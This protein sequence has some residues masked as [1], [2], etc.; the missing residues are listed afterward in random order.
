MTATA[1]ESAAA[2]RRAIQ[3]CA[4]ITSRMLAAAEAGDWGTVAEL[5]AERRP[6]FEGV[7]LMALDDAELRPMLEGLRAL[8]AMDG[9][10]SAWADEARQG[11]LEDLRRARGRA[12][13]SK[14][15]EQLRY[16]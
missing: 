8:V 13:G 14:R 6:C 3:A 7:D 9:R 11:A 12:R 4:D 2:A 10:L 15:Y 16:G 1:N 5:D